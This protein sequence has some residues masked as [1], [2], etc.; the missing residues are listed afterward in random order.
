MSILSRTVSNP[1]LSLKLNHGFNHIFRFT[2]SLQSTSTDS[3]AATMEL[4]SENQEE[5]QG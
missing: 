1:T 5:D 4:D 3:T 2:R